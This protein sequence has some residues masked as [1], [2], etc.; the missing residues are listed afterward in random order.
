[1]LIRLRP[2]RMRTP[3]GPHGGFQAGRPQA[4]RAGER[5]TAPRA[6]VH[7]WR[8]WLAPG[9]VVAVVLAM[10]SLQRADLQA[11]RAEGQSDIGVVNDRLDQVDARHHPR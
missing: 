5:H 11:F 6:V 3:V 2:G 8:Q 9:V 7:G 1:M 4:R 10:G